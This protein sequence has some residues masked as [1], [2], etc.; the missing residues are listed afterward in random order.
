M[1]MDWTCFQLFKNY[2][3]ASE[4]GIEEV[5]IKSRKLET[6]NISSEK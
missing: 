6:E 4:V 5:D 2:I 1:M 3:E